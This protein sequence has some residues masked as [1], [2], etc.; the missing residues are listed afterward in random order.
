VDAEPADRLAPGGKTSSKPPPSLPGPDW[1]VEL[2]SWPPDW[3]EAWEERAAI[4]EYDAGLPRD[5]AERSA[6]KDVKGHMVRNQRRG[7]A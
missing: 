6:F 5:E 1:R 7:N 3:R 2:A 4:M